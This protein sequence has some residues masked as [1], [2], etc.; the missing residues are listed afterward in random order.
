[1][2]DD[3]CPNRLKIQILLCLHLLSARK[4]ETSRLNPP[5]IN[6][7]PS[8]PAKKG[9]KTA[10]RT[11][12]PV[13]RSSLSPKKPIFPPTN[14][15]SVGRG[16]TKD[17]VRISQDQPQKQSHHD[18]EERLELLMDRLSIAQL[19]ANLPTHPLGPSQPSTSTA[20]PTNKVSQDPQRD[21]I[22]AFCEEIVKPL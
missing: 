1:M 15:T 5:A 21:W 10:A 13:L 2:L 8:T 20:V 16:K 18:I 19:V 17:G 14:S 7:I 3:S 6:I 22:Q 11:K 9:A 12:G 4:Q